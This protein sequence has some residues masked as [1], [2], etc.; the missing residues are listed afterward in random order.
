MRSL[1]IVGFALAL[2]ACHTEPGTVAPPLT[3]APAS[4][5][6]PSAPSSSAAAIEPP[7]SSA[8]ASAPVASAPSPVAAAEEPVSPVQAQF[9]DLATKPEV[10]FRACEQYFVAIARGKA[11]AAGESLAV[12]DVLLAQG[13][14]GFSVT[15]DGLA[16]IASVRPR[17]CEP[18][19]KGG[20]VGL[21][22]KVVRAT[23]APELTWAG[24]AMHAHLDAE[25]EISP[26][27][28]IGRLEGTAAVAEHAHEGAWEILCAVEG[29]GT[30][31]I[32]GKEQRLGPRQIVMVPPSTKHAWKPDAGT[33]LVAIQLY[34]PPGPEQRFKAL[35]A[36]AKK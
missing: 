32:A 12:G 3:A 15:G 31:T 21:T 28:Y 1:P 2:F 22:K 36:D 20:P 4:A 34:T 6:P 13:N 24:G 26:L 19:G 5:N 25:G 23:A 10:K 16:L 7:A 8:S 35:A 18:A 33:K 17:V 14:Q 9:V 27:A 30:F 29:A 11:K